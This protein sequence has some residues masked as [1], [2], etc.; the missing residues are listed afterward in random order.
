[1]KSQGDRERGAEGVGEGAGEGGGGR[2]MAGRG[3]YTDE[4]APRLLPVFSDLASY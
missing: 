3:A 2:G 4:A 1:M